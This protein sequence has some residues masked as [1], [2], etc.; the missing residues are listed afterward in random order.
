MKESP[1][2]IRRI[3][4]TLQF[5][6]GSRCYPKPEKSADVKE[7][8]PKLLAEF[9]MIIN[10]CDLL[11]DI[12][13]SPRNNITSKIT[14]DIDY[15]NDANGK[16]I[17]RK[18]SSRHNDDEIYRLIKGLITSKRS[19]SYDRIDKI[20]EINSIDMRDRRNITKDIPLAV[21]D[22]FWRIKNPPPSRMNY[23]ATDEIE[24]L[25]KIDKEFSNRTKERRRRVLHPFDV[26][27][28]NG[29]LDQYGQLS[30]TIKSFSWPLTI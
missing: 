22:C 30:N 21:Y 7:L 28:E 24:T 1:T 13:Y 16:E 26:V 4:N 14:S 3:I 19:S 25:Y 23:I 6:S 8:N 9:D 5:Y 29:R 18:Q 17:S 11:N 27:D 20:S 10:Q 12:S 15:G 2:D